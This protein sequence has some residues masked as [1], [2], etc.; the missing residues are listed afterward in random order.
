MTSSESFGAVFPQVNAQGRVLPGNQVAIF[1]P[2]W[3][4][5]VRGQRSEP[6]GE[7]M[8]SI[9]HISRSGN[10]ILWMSGDERFDV[11]DQYVGEGLHCF[12]ACPGNMRGDDQIW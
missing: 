11:V 1:I 7:W 4:I 9:A 6:G 8:F 10:D 2:M 3:G 12:I 5:E